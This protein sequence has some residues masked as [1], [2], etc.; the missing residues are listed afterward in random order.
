[1]FCIKFY[2]ILAYVQVVVNVCYTLR[3]F[4]QTLFTKGVDDVYSVCPSNSGC[5]RIVG[6]PRG[7]VGGGGVLP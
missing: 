2:I 6:R 7:P 5:T 1:M 3:V 4:V